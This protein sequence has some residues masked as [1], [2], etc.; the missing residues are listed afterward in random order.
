MGRRTDDNL[1]EVERV[2]LAEERLCSSS[3][4]LGWEKSLIV[5]GIA[6]LVAIVVWALVF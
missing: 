2:M 1:D 3:H 5:W 6:I 4:L